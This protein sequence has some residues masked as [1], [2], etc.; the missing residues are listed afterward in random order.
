MWCLAAWGVFDEASDGRAGGS[1]V[2]RHF[3]DIQ[4]QGGESRGWIVLGPDAGRAGPGGDRVQLLAGLPQRNDGDLTGLGV[5]E[6][7]IA[8]E[9]GQLPSAGQLL[10]SQANGPV[11]PLTPGLGGDHAREHHTPSG[12]HGYAYVQATR[13]TAG[14]QG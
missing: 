4:A 7:V 12:W 5:G 8:L 13:A 9:P 11:E 10:L 3:V 6:Q 1:G 2:Q 14:A